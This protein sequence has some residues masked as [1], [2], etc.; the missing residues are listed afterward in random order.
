MGCQA[1][2]HD[3]AVRSRLAYMR[4]FAWTVAGILAAGLVIAIA[5][6]EFIA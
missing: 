3:E 4:D 5:F 2:E 6:R 1:D